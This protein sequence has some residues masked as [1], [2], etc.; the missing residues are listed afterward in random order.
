MLNTTTATLTGEEVAIAKTAIRVFRVMAAIGVAIAIPVVLVIALP[1]LSYAL[2]AGLILAPV[3][4]GVVL[5]QAGRRSV[6]RAS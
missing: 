1:F 4:V 5:Y 6:P 3:L 2:V